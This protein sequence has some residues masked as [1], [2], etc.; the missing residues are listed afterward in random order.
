MTIGDLARR[1][2]CGIETIR[3]YEREGL[4]PRTARTGGNYRR[5]ELGHAQLL[6]FIRQCRSLDMSLEEI[7]ILLRFRSGAQEN[8]SEVN[9]LL[10]IHLRHVEG[11]IAELQN[12]ERQLQALREKCHSGKATADCGI[13]R[14]LGDASDDRD[15]SGD[16]HVPRTHSTKR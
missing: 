7:R 15:A 14:G 4:L 12:L 6:S 13:L 16:N 1:T 9:A 11:R 5:Y 10:D 2:G 3:Y 8:C